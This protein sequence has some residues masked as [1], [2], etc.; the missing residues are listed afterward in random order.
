MVPRGAVIGTACL[1]DAEV[2]VWYQVGEEQAFTLLT[3]ILSFLTTNLMLDLSN[4]LLLKNSSQIWR[5]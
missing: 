5:K 3:C 1:W 4:T 2:G